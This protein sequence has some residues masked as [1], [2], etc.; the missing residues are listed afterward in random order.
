MYE[1]QGI[2]YSAA[3]Q[4]LQGGPKKVYISAVRACILR[5]EPEFLLRENTQPVEL[6]EIWISHIMRLAEPR[7][8]N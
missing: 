3:F 7:C 2:L 5:P 4:C 8:H 6:N 1:P